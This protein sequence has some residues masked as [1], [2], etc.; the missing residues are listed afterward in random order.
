MSYM[1]NLAIDQLN[2][3][4][5]PKG[6][7]IGS[8]SDKRDYSASQI[9]KNKEYTI[10]DGIHT[11]RGHTLYYNSKGILKCPCYDAKY[12]VCKHI[13]AFRILLSKVTTI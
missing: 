11:I 2:G 6:L 12:N 13:R 10:K 5:I 9:I 7:I 8:F 4:P 3:I 1:K